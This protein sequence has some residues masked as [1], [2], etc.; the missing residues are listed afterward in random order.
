MSDSPSAWGFELHCWSLNVNVLLL[1]TSELNF[2]WHLLLKPTQ[3][4]KASESTFQPFTLSFRSPDHSEGGR[5]QPSSLLCASVDGVTLKRAVWEPSKRQ[6][7]PSPLGSHSER[8]GWRSRHRWG[9]VRSHA[10]F[11]KG[12][13]SGGQKWEQVCGTPPKEMR[14]FWFFVFLVPKKYI[15]RKIYTYN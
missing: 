10:F 8:W 9:E 5:H 13:V 3:S 15:L 7:L 1:W 2:K 6:L 4:E 11:T 14:F 12:Q